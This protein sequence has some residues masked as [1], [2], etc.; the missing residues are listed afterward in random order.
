MQAT[1]KTSVWRGQVLLMAIMECP[2]AGDVFLGRSLHII[3]SCKVLN[4]LWMLLVYLPSGL[5]WWNSQFIWD[6]KIFGYIFFIFQVAIQWWRSE[7]IGNVWWARA[8]PR[9]ND[10]V[11]QLGW[12]EIPNS[13]GKNAKFLATKQP[14]SRF[15]GYVGAIF[16]QGLRSKWL[17]DLVDMFFVFKGVNQS[18]FKGFE[19]EN[20]TFERKK[21]GD[22]TRGNWMRN[23]DLT[24]IHRRK[25]WVLNMVSTSS[26]KMFHQ[27]VGLNVDST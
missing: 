26:K 27:Y 10:G 21:C 8:T 9:K 3:Q 22:F 4:H 16:T 17:K 11:R 18:T 15:C 14:P 23:V 19:A 25:L 5:G 2:F 7:F 13:Y 12:L 20:I 24:W 1:A 6:N